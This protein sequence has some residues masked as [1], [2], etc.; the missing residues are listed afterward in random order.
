MGEAQVSARQKPPKAA[1]L[2]LPPRISENFIIIKISNLPARL[3]GGWDG[4]GWGGG[5]WVMRGGAQWFRVGG[6]A[7]EGSVIAGS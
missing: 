5:C 7:V 1:P 3:G 4:M 2:G 6:S